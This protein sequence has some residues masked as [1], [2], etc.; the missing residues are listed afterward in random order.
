MKRRPK[1]TQ[2]FCCKLGAL[3]FK[4]LGIPLHYEK[5]RREDIQPVVDKIIK[6]IAGWQGRLMLYGARLELLK[7]C[8]ASIPIYL[9]SMIR[10]LKW[11]IETI[12]SHMAKFFWDDLKGKHKYHLSIWLSLAQ[13]K[14]YGGIGVPDLRDLN[15]CLLASWIQKYQNSDSRLWKSIIDNKYHTN[16]LNILCCDDRNSSPFWKGVC[17]VAHAARMGFRWRVGD[18]K[19]VRFW[20]DQ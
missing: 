11:A 2:I 13:K 9:M 4:Y 14:E 20:K 6:R 7:A 15:L 12:N 17:W 3:S 10:F 16:S 1:C 18:G 8:I 19:K 5:L